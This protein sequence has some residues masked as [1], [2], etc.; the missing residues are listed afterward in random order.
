M[1]CITAKPGDTQYSLLKK[2]PE[3]KGHLP[4]ELKAGVKYCTPDKKPASAAKPAAA[5]KPAAV[6]KPEP[7]A[8]TSPKK[9]EP[10][11]KSEKPIVQTTTYTVK[12]GD[13]LSKISKKFAAM[14]VLL[15]NNPG[16][17]PDKI[18]VGM[19]L[20]VSPEKYKGT[21]ITPEHTKKLLEASLKKIGW[22]EPLQ[23]K[24]NLELLAA[25]AETENTPSDKNK[26]GS[27]QKEKS[28]LEWGWEKL[29]NFLGL[30]SSDEAF[31]A[32]A[33]NKPEKQQPKLPF[34]FVLTEQKPEHEDLADA[35]VNLIGRESNYR[36]DVLN[37]FKFAGLGQMGVPTL[38]EIG[39]VRPKKGKRI[40]GNNWQ[41]ME[42]TGKFGLH[43]LKDFL[44][45]PQA[46]AD[47]LVLSLKRKKESLRKRGI[48]EYIGL[49]VKD[50]PVENK[51]SPGAKDYPLEELGV[52][53]ASHLVGPRGLSLCLKTGSDKY[54][55]DG[56]KI[57]V[58]E[59]TKLP[60]PLER[61][62][63]LVANNP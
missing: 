35:M 47:C 44:S 8:E 58:L 38:E 52:V 2:Y 23:A 36:I 12:P 30:N 22:G 50:M 9:S 1:T 49:T 63:K 60:E 48:E 3:L 34:N 43:S 37:Q 54:C 28:L 16:L 62:N 31:A 20:N 5:K 40:S 32:Q 29:K 53:F 33:E 11:K 61:N 45:D 17:N 18:K 21:Y 57:H 10:A 6:S 7:K 46:Q 4:V 51:T 25:Q 15:Y 55:M 59:Y 41:D 24:P 42:W 19:V 27:S 39:V 56:N 13:T 14:D 26:A